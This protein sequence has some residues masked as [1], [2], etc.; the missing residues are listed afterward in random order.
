M[1]IA[2]RLS[3]EIYRRRLPFPWNAIST[4][5][6]PLGWL[7]GLLMR[8]RAAAYAAGWRRSARPTCRVISVGNLTM[9]GTGKTPVT[10][11]LARELAAAGRRVVVVSRGYHGAGEGRRALVVADRGG[12]R[13]D[14]ATAGDEP[15]LL[16]KRL[17]GV[18]VVVGSRRAD[19]VALA[20]R[21]FDCEV[22][23][24]DDAFSHLAL[25]RDVDVV[26][27]HGR[28]GLG[29]CRVVPAGPLRE[30]RHAMRRADAVVLNVTTGDDP[31]V[32]DQVLRAGFSG[33]VFKVRYTAPHLRRSDGSL[34]EAGDLAGPG[35]LAFAATARPRDFFVG[36]SRAG[37]PV[38]FTKAFPDHHAYTAGDLQRLAQLA[39]K[40][41]I[42]YLATT[43]KDAVKLPP[44]LPDGPEL[45]VAEIDL[46]GEDDDLRRLLTLVDP[47]LN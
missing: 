36:L 9:G 42:C 35:V 41:G 16:A 15:V 4:C 37:I 8:L 30:P 18:P 40:M 11:V 29:N 43:E 10:L 1:T 27:V 5:L 26:L 25:R 32:S 12:L 23:I 7:Y 28:D 24:C 34:L 33:P 46:V 31:G 20:Q 17:P 14:A 45:L 3:R 21:E 39:A 13:L 6:A 47:A 38:A 19:A 2:G 44:P 22:V